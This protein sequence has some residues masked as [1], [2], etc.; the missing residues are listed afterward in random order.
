MHASFCTQWQGG[1]G[2]A[3][4]PNVHTYTPALLRCYNTIAV[5]LA[6]ASLIFILRSLY[7]KNVISIYTF[8]QCI[9][10]QTMTH[11]LLQG[12]GKVAGHHGVPDGIISS[13]KPTREWHSDGLHEL[14]EP[15]VATSMYSVSVKPVGGDTL[16]MSGK[17]IY[18]QLAEEEQARANTATVSVIASSM[19]LQLHQSHLR[20]TK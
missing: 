11:R 6:G 19:R 13:G 15:P 5:A 12:E 2:M 4:V 8:L 10:F 9:C 1:G 17:A 7:I 18:D 20:C 3:H 16:F 14:Q